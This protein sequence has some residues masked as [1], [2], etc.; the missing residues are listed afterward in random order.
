[1]I[2]SSIDWP[3]AIE[4]AL[5]SISSMVDVLPIINVLRFMLTPASRQ[6]AHALAREICPAGRWRFA[7]RG[8]AAS[9]PRSTIRLNAIAQVRAQNIA[10]RISPKVR[11]PGQPRLSRAATT[12]AAGVT[13]PLALAGTTLMA[14]LFLTLMIYRLALWFRLPSNV[15]VLAGVAVAGAAPT[16]LAEQAA[17]RPWVGLIKRTVNPIYCKCFNFAKQSL[18]HEISYFE[19]VAACLAASIAVL[20]I[21]WTGVADATS[22]WIS[23]ASS[24]T[25]ARDS[26]NAMV[27]WGG[28]GIPSTSTGVCRSTVVPSPN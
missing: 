14:G 17:G 25:C 28:S 8:F 16:A 18:Q 27:C 26:S 2:S 23:S 21:G 15:V 13:V 5:A 4:F 9:N 10:S 1:M 12:I 6:S 22:P 24:I 7:V 11:Q 19:R 20:A 3:R